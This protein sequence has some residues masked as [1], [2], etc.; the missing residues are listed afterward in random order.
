MKKILWIMIIALIAIVGY[1]AAGPHIT[2]EK[3]KTGIVEN[4]SEQLAENI[5]FPKLRQNMKEQFNAGIM[6][7]TAPELQ[8]NPFAA[9]GM[10]LAG[11]MVDGLVDAFVTPASLANV[12]EGKKQ[13]SS[14][15]NKQETPEEKKAKLFKNARYSYD[16]LDKFSIWMPNEQGGETRFVL[17]RQGLSWKLV[18]I[19]MPMNQ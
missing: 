16:S 10:A 14:S 5:E 1:A 9:F 18:N 8:N 17:A 4:D 2:L 7:Q 19:I 6:Q 13:Y 3:I 11:K 15:S 12:M